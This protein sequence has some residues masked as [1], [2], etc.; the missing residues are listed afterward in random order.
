[1]DKL[2]EDIVEL[3]QLQFM[4]TGTLATLI[5]KTLNKE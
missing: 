1:M 2:R 3:L 5:E 4:R